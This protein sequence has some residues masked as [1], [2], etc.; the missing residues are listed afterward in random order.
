MTEMTRADLLKGLGL[1]AV[2]VTLTTP[3][4]HADAE[5]P[6]VRLI[7]DYYATYAKS[8]PEQPA[9]TTMSPKT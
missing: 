8:D 3:T 1:A 7:K 2:G 9:T 6:N 5:H 4:A